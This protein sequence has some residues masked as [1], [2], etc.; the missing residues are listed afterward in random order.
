VS[1]G[2]YS[3]VHTVLVSRRDARDPLELWSAGYTNHGKK[4]PETK[5]CVRPSASIR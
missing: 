1:P 3:G 2:S 4:K 5:A